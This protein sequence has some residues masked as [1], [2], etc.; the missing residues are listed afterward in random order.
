MGVFMSKYNKL[1]LNIQSLRM[2]YGESQNDLGEI[3]HVVK[4]TVSNY[5]NGSRT[6]NNEILARIADHYLVSV[7]ELLNGD[8]SHYGKIQFDI[9]N[10]WKGLDIILPIFKLAEHRGRIEKAITEMAEGR[11]K[12]MCYLPDE[13]HSWEQQKSSHEKGSRS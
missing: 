12:E 7:E 1:G 11:W 3:I 13:D 9:D 4:T 8:F 6:P 5:E 2:A 10:G